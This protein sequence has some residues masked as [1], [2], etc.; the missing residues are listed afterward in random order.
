MK[1]YSI[2]V[3]IITHNRSS[4]LKETLNSLL[5][6]TVFPREILVIDNASSDK[7]R[8]T[9]L[10]FK[11]K[12]P[13]KYIY[14][15]TIGIP[16]A[17]NRA[18][19][20]AR[21]EIIAFIDDDCTANQTWIEEIINA[22]QGKSDVIAI[23]G[24]SDSNLNTLYGILSQKYHHAWLNKNSFKHG[25]IK[26]LDTK[27][28]SFKRKK[29][30]SLGILFDP[31]LVRGSDAD[32][33]KRLLGKKQQIVFAPEISIN[34][35]PRETLFSFLKHRFIVGFYNA[36]LQYKWPKLF[37]GAKRIRSTYQLT[38]PTH[39]YLSL[40][41][42]FIVASLA[43]TSYRLGFWVGGIAI[44]YNY[45][46]LT[47][48]QLFTH[49]FPF[50][51]KLTLSVMI[52]T[53]NRRNSLTQT[54]LSLTNQTQKPHEVIVVDSSNR[55]DL[56]LIEEFQELNI[57]YIYEKKKG[58]GVARNTAITNA[59]GDII[60]TIDDDEIAAKD[61]CENILKAHQNDPQA[62]A[63]QGRFI[64]TPINS[65]HAI[66]EQTQLDRWL[67]LKMSSENQLFTISTKNVSF[68]TKVIK[69]L[70][71]KLRTNRLYGQYGDDVDFGYQMLSHKLKIAYYPD[72][73]VYHYER[74]NLFS[75]L[76]QQYRKGCSRALIEK[77]WGK[78]ERTLLDKLI[79]RKKYNL[80]LIFHPIAR[81]NIMF[82]PLLIVIFL[83]SKISYAKGLYSM[84]NKLKKRTLM[85]NYKIETEVTLNPLRILAK[86]QKNLTQHI[87][88]N[89]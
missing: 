43:K 22:H 68:K 29:L 30:L 58:F 21:E 54:L 31:K 74:P 25:K 34:F 44:Y 45:D 35:N 2:S 85:N 28:C 33:A 48:V 78:F 32:I 67:L 39:N 12:L 38:L 59:R 8:E 17:R 71:I 75:Y 19:K 10:Q 26:I 73:I 6:Q 62:T 46:R 37:S 77:D 63:I 89:L 14:E 81:K 1:N 60:A 7:T 16:N 47:K 20:E 76:Q 23:Q 88:Q 82:I 87:L 24:K 11:N 61:W 65:P 5:K 83:F 4:Q 40:L 42:L 53:K 13:I 84:R 49:N 3:A 64:C 52:I 9:T 56:T 55:K 15:T 18:L 69:K 41:L 36:K 27:N 57:T 80:D 86:A 51:K 72:I 79:K 50:N 70:K 66:V